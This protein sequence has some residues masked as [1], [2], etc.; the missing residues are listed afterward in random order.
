MP[1]PTQLAGTSTP[2]EVRYGTTGTQRRVTVFFRIILALPQLIVVGAL[3]YAAYLLVFLGWFAALFTGR[4]PQAFARF[5]TGYLR[6]YVRVLAYTYLMTDEYP[7][8]SLDPDMRYPVDLTVTTG[9]L[10]RASVF[11]RIILAFPALVVVSVLTFGWQILSFFF[12]MITLVKGRMPESI[13]GATAATIRYAV[14]TAGF[15]AMVTS[16]YPGGVFGD[17]APDGS[18]VEVAESGTPPDPLPPPAGGWTPAPDRVPAPPPPPGTGWA[19]SPAPAWGATPAAVEPVPPPG[20]A[21]VPPPVPPSVTPLDPAPTGTPGAEAAAPPAMPAPGSTPPPPPLPVP[22]PPPPPP[23]P[24]PT[25]ATGVPSSPPPPPPPPPPPFAPVAT[26]APF[27][28][29]VPPPPVGFDAGPWR[30]W[31]LLLSRA[32][33]T[34]TIVLVV[35]G[36]IGLV[37]YMVVIPASVHITGIGSVLAADETQLAYD[38]LQT[39]SNTFISGSKS[40]RAN[41]TSASEELQCLQATDATFATAVQ[42]YGSGLNGISYPSSA[43]GEADAA[44]AAAHR[45]DVQMQSL[46]AA[47]DAQTY[48]AIVDGTAFSSSLQALDSTFTQLMNTLNGG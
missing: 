2:V 29:P 20:P 21:A 3:G 25:A 10:N 1:Q 48:Q 39:Q 47:P 38:T 43:Q 4:L 46:A 30:V 33:R 34:L 23:P 14:R 6:W 37:A 8:F 41:A 26:G 18:R 11:F 7:P 15:F 19:S 16:V 13:F 24:F 32:A 12:W 35:I 28:A 22:P 45:V 9:R 31:P 44:I 17:T 42:G 40:C 27:P 36:S 5:I